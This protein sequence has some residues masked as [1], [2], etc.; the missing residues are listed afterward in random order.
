MSRTGD[1][2]QTYS[3]LKMYPLDPRPEEINLVDIAHA[4]SNICR[5]TG[6]CG[7]FYSVAQHSVYV[8]VY[9]SQENA[10]WGLLHDAS[11]AYL[12]DIARPIKR[13][14]FLKGYRECEDVL[15]QCIAEKFGLPWPIPE[16]ILLL[17]NRFMMAEVRDLGLLS[18]DWRKCADPIPT[19]IHPQ[20]PK[21]A[22]R[23][24]W[25]WYEVLKER[26]PLL[27]KNAESNAGAGFLIID[28]QVVNGPKILNENVC[29]TGIASPL[30]GGDPQEPHDCP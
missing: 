7:E 4:L 17:D 3:G 22:E 10:L 20:L 19:I 30:L 12:C 15:M 14:V 1:W 9:A 13:S 25:D 28:G 21:Q 16:E 23:S 8:S 27:K 6:H 18:K 11:E 26:S 29:P 5:Y 2:I 24:F